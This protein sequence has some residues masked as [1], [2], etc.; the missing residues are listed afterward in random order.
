MRRIPAHEATC[1]PR[2]SRRLPQ[3][4]VAALA[5][6]AALAAPDEIQVYTDDINAPAEMG[7]EIHASYVTRGRDSAFYEGERPP[8]HVLRMTTGF[9]FGLAKGWDAG[10]YLPMTK[11]RGIFG[12]PF[13]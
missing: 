12:I 1:F 5:G 11:L 13:N 7:L 4:F 6:P 8:F 10:F 9:S 2:F 3:I